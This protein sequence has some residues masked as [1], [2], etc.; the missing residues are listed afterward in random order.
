MV[1]LP[2]NIINLICEWAAQEDI[3][4]Y[5]FFCPKTHKLSWK[6][7]KYS[8]KW[9]EKGDLILHNKLD[10][11]LVKGRLRF[12]HRY[13]GIILDNINFEAIIWKYINKTFKMYISFDSE[14]KENLKEKYIYRTMLDFE[15]TLEEGLVQDN[16]HIISFSSNRKDIY[17]NNS[18][19]GLI[20]SAS[21]AYEDS[22]PELFILID[23]Y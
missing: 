7:N 20:E 14:I 2:V 5:P 13:N 12:L 8:K 10:S 21:F 3:E 22:I 9:L 16:Y 17:L 19:F 1:R 18:I 23:T 11:F 6:V 4:W 15:G